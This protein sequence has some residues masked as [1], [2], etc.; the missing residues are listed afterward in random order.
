MVDNL[1][2]KPQNGQS[3]SIDISSL[4]DVANQSASTERVEKPVIANPIQAE[5]V[6]IDLKVQNQI[7]TNKD[8]ASKRYHPCILTVKTK[9][10]NPENNEEFVSRDN[11]SGL[12]FFFKTDDFGNPV[13][14]VN[15]E[16]QCERLWLGDTSGLGKL[17]SKA[18][19]YDK[20]IVS[21]QDFF[22][23]LSTHKNC[24]IKTEYVNNPRNG[25]QIKKEIIQSFI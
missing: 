4:G 11:Y 9:F 12:R 14:D 3:R 10:I 18:Q 15:G 20:T 23:F 25:E 21:Y 2:Q 6:D 16:E 1:I 5:I 19:A 22:N 7:N 13:L 8:D 24:M 17:L